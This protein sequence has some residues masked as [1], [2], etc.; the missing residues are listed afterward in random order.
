[1]KK[2]GDR[3]ALVDIKN[4]IDVDTCPHLQT[5]AEGEK[6]RQKNN[7]KKKGQV[8]EQPEERT[9]PADRQD[10]QQP[11]KRKYPLHNAF[12]E[13][14]DGSLE[15]IERLLK[16]RIGTNNSSIRRK[17]YFKTFFRYDSNAAQV[18]F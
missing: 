8:K 6:K 3:L 13:L 18:W 14:G 12:R 7:R 2:E 9:R 10:R 1:M 16:G 11:V 15:T 4:R 5:F 17:E